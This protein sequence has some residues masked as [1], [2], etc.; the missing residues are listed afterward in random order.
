M[1]IVDE[2]GKLLEEYRLYIGMASKGIPE[3][4]LSL[5][6]NHREEVIADL[7]YALLNHG[8][9]YL[10]NYDNLLDQNII[11]LALDQ[12]SRAFRL[13]QKSKDSITITKSKH[14][15][16]Y[17]Q[18]I[19]SNGLKFKETFNFC[20]CNVSSPKVKGQ[21]Y[22][23][24]IGQNQYPSEFQNLEKAIDQFFSSL[25]K[26]G[27][28]IIRLIFESLSIDQRFASSYIDL[29]TENQ[30]QQS[31]LQLNHFTGAKPSSRDLTY[32][33]HDNAD[34][35]KFLIQPSA[36]HVQDIYGNW[37]EIPPKP[38]SIILGVGQLLDCLSSG[39]CISRNYK[40]TFEPGV[41]GLSYSPILNLDAKLKPFKLTE[42][43][44][45]EKD[46][47]DELAMK[48]ALNKSSL[49]EGD[50]V[51]EKIFE[52]KIRH[53]RI[54]AE[55]WYPEVLEKLD[56]Q[57]SS[58]LDPEKQHHDLVGKIK[59]L[60]KI[61]FAL[62]KAV[63]LVIK[64]R[65]SNAKVLEIIPQVKSFTGFNIGETELLQVA[66]IWPEAIPLLL[67]EYNEVL[68]NTDEAKDSF[69]FKNLSKRASTFEAKA[70]EWLHKNRDRDDIP[71]L[72]RSE[73]RAPLDGPVTKRVKRSILQNSKEK[74]I[75]KAVSVETE[76]AKTGM[77]MLERI[78]LKERQKLETQ[79][80]P[81]EKYEHFL[82]GKSKAVLEIL[83][84]VR[85]DTPY[86]LDKLG[87]LI[88]NSLTKNPVSEKEAIDVALHLTN[89]FPEYFTL[90]KTKDSQI[91]KWKELDR[92]ELLSRLKK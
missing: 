89:K 14:F 66:F 69:N 60:I 29:G 58:K 6:D 23:N 73:I 12:A 48:E 19:S 1:Y 88:K 27:L 43:L 62:D 91:L 37:I 41:T 49:K 34:F 28:T 17:K 33:A 10:K 51:G 67:N 31:E 85:P 70:Q 18:E 78:R 65:T 20:S 3:I 57:N 92:E 56:Q 52:T 11:D 71:A 83:I 30:I 84:S 79:K 16:G 82:D 54:V 26:L 47:R 8:F 7:R 25:N 87:D 64:N 22:H 36:L 72:P 74:F 61:F 90:V 53:N 68:I 35:L 63:P 55:I 38:N 86:P 59:R 2:L 42:E 4:D 76:T 50:I 40:A 80:T 15:L 5:L 75:P 39:V 32:I 44:Q 45:F 24:I 81:E 46:Q 77:S 9:F 13:S 21:I